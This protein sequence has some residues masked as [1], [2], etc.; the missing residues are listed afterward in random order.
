MAEKYTR[1]QLFKLYEKLPDELKDAILSEGTADSIESVCKRNNIEGENIS[2]VAEYTGRV[3]LGVLPPD[4][5]QKTLEKEV[6][7]KKE[8]AKK[9]A[10][11]IN[12]FIFFPV[13]SSLEE[14]YK[15]E[16]APPARPKV[17][18]PP[19]VAPKKERKPD[20]YREPIE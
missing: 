13:K 10:R 14:I 18:P 16:I 12:R 1:E 20:V 17:T 9:V 7:L 6:K 2:K 19:E 3:L 11:E 8:V 4:E 5:F 15:I